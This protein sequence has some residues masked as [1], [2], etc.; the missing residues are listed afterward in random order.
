M[1]IN[2]L[3]RIGLGLIAITTLTLAAGSAR[4][5][6]VTYTTLGTFDSGAQAGSSVYDDGNVLITFENI[7]LQT[8]QVGPPPVS[9]LSF[10][11][12]NTTGTTGSLANVNSGFKLEI[13]QSSPG[14]TTPPQLMLVGTLTGSLSGNASTAFVQFSGF[15]PAVLPPPFGVAGLIGSLTTPNEIVTY[16]LTEADN[17]V[18]GKAN[19]VPPSVNN[20]VSSVEGA[21]TLVIPEP[22]SIAL[23]GLGGVVVGTLSVGRR[24]APVGA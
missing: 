14:P 8:V 6:M 22:S 7:F 2:T 13:F 1:K 3:R 9:G 21:I 16:Y 11:N 5:A 4:S 12:F 18:L 17:G 24:R 15:T 19:I 23:V 20:G 10:G